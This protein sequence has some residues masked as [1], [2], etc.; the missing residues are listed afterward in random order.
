MEKY[1]EYIVII[2]ERAKDTDIKNIYAI[3]ERKQELTEQ[4]LKEDIIELHGDD[5]VFLSIR[6]KEISLKKFLELENEIH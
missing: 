3:T 4:S 2:K 1:Y 5:V 6:I